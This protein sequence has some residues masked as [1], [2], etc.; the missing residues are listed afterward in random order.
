MFRILSEDSAINVLD[1]E[2]DDGDLLHAELTG[3]L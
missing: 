2:A 3:R 1:V